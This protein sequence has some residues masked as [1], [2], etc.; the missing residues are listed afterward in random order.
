MRF[1]TAL[2]LVT[3]CLQAA[4]PVAPLPPGVGLKDAQGR[5]NGVRFVDINGDGHD[6]LVF[7][8]AERYGVYLFND[9]ERKNLGWPI[10][11]PHIIREGKASGANAL[12]LTTGDDVV[13]KDDAMWVK[14]LTY[15]ELCRPPTPAYQLRVGVG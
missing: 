15:A 13:F 11:W 8:N 5:D 9:V 10:G 6:D 14:A 7:S 2:A 1:A 12:P 4:A 3:Y